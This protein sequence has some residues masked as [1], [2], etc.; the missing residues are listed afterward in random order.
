M[1]MFLPAIIIMLSMSACNNNSESTSPGPDSSVITPDNT[2]NN[3]NMTDTMVPADSSR[4]N[5]TIA[6]GR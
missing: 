1:K 5:D 4:M 6:P 2:M 3:Q